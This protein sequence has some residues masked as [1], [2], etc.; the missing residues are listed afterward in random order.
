MVM[1]LKG[2]CDD[3]GKGHV[4]RSAQ[5]LAEHRLEKQPL[6]KRN[7]RRPWDTGVSALCGVAGHTTTH[8]GDT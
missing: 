4:G 2:L 6:T 8:T 5:G 7:D 3:S 1:Y